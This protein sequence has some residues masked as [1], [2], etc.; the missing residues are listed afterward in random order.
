MLRINNYKDKH[1]YQSAGG[2]TSTVY[3]MDCIDFLQQV[4]EK[5]FDLAVVDPPYG[6]NINAECM[7]GRKTVKPNKQKKWDSEVPS[8]SYFEL[9]F[10]KS[11][12]QIIWG[13]N[14][15]KLPQSRYFIIWDKGETMYGRDFAECEYAWAKFG[16]TRIF[17]EFPNQ[18]DRIHPTQKPV[19]LYDWIYQNYAKPGQ[20]V[21]DTHLGSGSNR[22]AAHKYN[23]DFVGV[24][25]DPEYFYASVKRFEQYTSQLTLF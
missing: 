2:I 11:Y 13:G 22:I 5:Y 4:T 1:V 24:E 7:G 15:F 9:L 17:K 16:G 8:D 6:I 21:L 25:L 19:K 10:D 14:Y 20:V 3:L 23:L 18:L 12:N